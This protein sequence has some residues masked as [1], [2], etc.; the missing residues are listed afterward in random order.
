MSLLEGLGNPDDQSALGGAAAAKA[1]TLPVCY[2]DDEPDN[3]ELF[4]LHFEHEFEILTASCA[5]EALELLA[6]REIGVLLTDERM[7]G[8]S[9]IDLLACVVERW[10]DVI[11]I[12]VS[13]YSDG[14]RLLG[15]LNRGHA[16]EYIVK[17]WSRDELGG[18]VQRALE[19]S[20]RRRALSA[21]AELADALIESNT[22]SNA[23]AQLIG[24]RPGGGLR[25]VHDLIVR[26]A[27][28][29]ATVLVLGETG[30]GKEL[31]ARTLHRLSRRGAGPFLALN[32]AAVPEGLIESELFGHEQGA[33]TGAGKS[34]KGRFELAQGGTLFLDEIGDISAR[35]QVAL[36]R[37]LQER[38]IERLGGTKS[39]PL[40]VRL[41][42]ATHRDLPLAI[43][44]GTFREDLYYRLNVVPL[45]VPPLRARSQDLRELV[46]H[47]TKKW[48]HSAGM[49]RPPRLSSA[50]IEMLGTY[51]WPGNVRELENMVQRALVLCDKQE[52]SVDDF[53]FACPL[54]GLAAIPEPSVRELV[55]QS[56]SRQLRELL[57]AHGGN[58]SRAARSSGVPR[59]TLLSRAKKFG[60]L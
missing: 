50:V 26:A 42:A 22:G 5:A 55:Q 41:V 7:P 45:H 60:L 23:E 39:I 15:A 20:R 3:L 28:S 47:F 21:K 11:R 44:D 31:V 57:L 17:P 48:A 35:V 16:H 32:C 24:T 49:R 54:A 10:P 56:E 53:T 46:E 1:E 37:A 59:T 12:I 58:I 13:A 33:F 6:T 25:G 27:A 19:M 34:R 30:T 18:C 38:T 51:T 8:M 4:R 9:G 29:D 43:R 2:V 52:I 14:A 40:D 36:L